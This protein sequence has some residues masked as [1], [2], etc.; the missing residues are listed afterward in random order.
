MTSKATSRKEE[1]ILGLENVILL[2][3]KFTYIELW[4][5]EDDA[6]KREK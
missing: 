5:D 3:Y 2:K 1:S 4:E 6:D